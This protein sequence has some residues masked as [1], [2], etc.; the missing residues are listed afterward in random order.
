MT[1]S[2][3]APRLAPAPSE[4]LRSALE[5]LSS[6]RFAIALL[7]VICI[8]SVIG[9]IVKQHEP[10]VNYVNQ[11]G[12]FWSQLFLAHQAQCRLQRL[13]VPADPGV[14][15][16]QHLAVHRPQHAR[17]SSRTCA[18]TRKTSASRACRP[19]TTGP[20]ACW[21]TR[22]PR[23]RAASARGWRA[24]A[25]RCR[26]QQR[27]TPQ[28]E[29]WMVAA[30]AGA[31]QQD[32]L[33]RRP[34]RHRAGLPGRAAGWR[35]DR[36]GPDVVRRQGALHRRRHDRRRRRQAP[37]GV[38]QP[39]LPRQRA[40]DRRHAV[41]H[42]HPVAVRRHPAA[43][44]AVLDRAEE[45]RDRALLHRHAQAVRQRHR[46]PR[47]PDRARRCRPASRSTTR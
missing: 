42:R 18:A 36:A 6:M 14:P 7:T 9:T 17:A 40:G 2:A 30:K 32:R 25:G 33:H 23:P 28:G 12:P 8:A 4:R 35:P 3:Q 37:A 46:D 11:F 21:P 16:D 15:G 45:V 13:V 29:G 19:S 34:Q 1:A 44:A 24:P 47:P 10:A 20:G 5:L 41:G 22:R 43:G 38:D 26:L 31:R 39:H 27:A